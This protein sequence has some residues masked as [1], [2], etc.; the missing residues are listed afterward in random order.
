MSGGQNGPRKFSEKIAIMERKLNEDEDAF[1][2]V[3]ERYIYI[4]LN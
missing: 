3:R 2:K 4:Y 1:S